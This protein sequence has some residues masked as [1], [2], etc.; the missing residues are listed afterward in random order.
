MLQQ[1]RISLV[2]VHGTFRNLSILL[3]IVGRGR[4]LKPKYGQQG[5][6][7]LPSS[8][9]EEDI[10]EHNLSMGHTIHTIRYE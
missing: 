8:V 9:G 4:L 7:R 1:V 5:T 2:F 10:V 3:L 6:L